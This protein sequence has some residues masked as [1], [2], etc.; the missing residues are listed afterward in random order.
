MDLD[1]IRDEK[2]G[3]LPAY[4]W[5][6]GY[7]VFYLSKHGLVLCPKCANDPAEAHE[8]PPVASGVNWEDPT[9][10]CDDCSEHIESAYAEED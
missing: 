2:T 5:P 1:A 6:G 7:P 4:A 8:D 9:L 3:K 10:F